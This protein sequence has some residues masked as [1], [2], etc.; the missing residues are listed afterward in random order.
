MTPMDT[1]LA[2]IRLSGNAILEYIREKNSF[3]FNLLA[4]KT[5]LYSKYSPWN[6]LFSSKIA[7][8]VEFLYVHAL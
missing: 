5:K 7:N 3:F 8:C 2:L 6:Y 4:T 1:I